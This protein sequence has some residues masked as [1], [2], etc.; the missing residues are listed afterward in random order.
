MTLIEI[1]NGCGGI[2]KLQHEVWRCLKCGA[3]PLGIHA[4]SVGCTHKECGNM[5]EVGICADTARALRE[6]AETQPYAV[7]D[8]IKHVNS[9]R[10]GRVESTRP[11]RDGT[12]EIQ[13]DAGDLGYTWWNS[14]HV[15]RFT[16]DED[17]R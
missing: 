1:H 10:I 13:V 4:V 7:G 16:A 17:K 14:V 9:H 11:Y 15:R 6:D 12:V 8:L 5:D 2:V 3:G